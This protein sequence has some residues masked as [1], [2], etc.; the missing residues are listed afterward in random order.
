[1]VTNPRMAMGKRGTFE[2]NMGAFARNKGRNG[3]NLAAIY[4]LPRHGAS[5]H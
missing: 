5:V 2:K 3:R 4:E 1:M